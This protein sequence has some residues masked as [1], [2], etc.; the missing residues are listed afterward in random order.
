M[1]MHLPPLSLVIE[2][3]FYLSFDL[4]LWINRISIQEMITIQQSALRINPRVPALPGYCDTLKIYI[5]LKTAIG[6]LC[7]S[8]VKIYVSISTIESNFL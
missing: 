2:T 4:L 3:Q 6:N 7:F 1:E 8:N 5:L